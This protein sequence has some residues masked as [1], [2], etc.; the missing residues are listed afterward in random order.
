[1]ENE[2]VTTFLRKVH[3]S[4]VNSIVFIIMSSSLS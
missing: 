2:N 4:L 1:M 3:N